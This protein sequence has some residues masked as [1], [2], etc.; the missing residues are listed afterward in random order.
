M[1]KDCVRTVL[2]R[3]CYYCACEGGL[4]AS[5]LMRSANIKRDTS[6]TYKKRNLSLNVGS[7]KFTRG[8][9]LEGLRVFNVMKR[10]ILTNAQ[11]TKG[12][13]IVSSQKVHLSC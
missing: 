4:A 1:W 6:P 12:D 8:I 9:D 3:L 13:A 11:F 5:A 7:W 2:S 10:L